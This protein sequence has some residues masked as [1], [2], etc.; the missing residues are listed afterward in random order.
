MQQQKRDVFQFNWMLQE[1]LNNTKKNHV[2]KHNKNC[3]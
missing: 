1:I 2:Y 3:Y